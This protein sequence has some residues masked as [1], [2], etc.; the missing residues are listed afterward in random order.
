MSQPSLPWTSATEDPALRWS[1]AMTRYRCAR[2]V[3]G[4]QGA[5]PQ[6]AIVEF[7]PPGASSRTGNPVPCSS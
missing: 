1:I 5:L 2:W 3:T 6:A 7:M 4:S